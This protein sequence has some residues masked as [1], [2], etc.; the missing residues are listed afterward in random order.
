M[1]TTFF[2]TITTVSTIFFITLVLGNNSYAEI[3]TENVL[4]RARNFTDTL[5]SATPPTDPVSGSFSFDYDD[6]LPDG[7]HFLKPSSVS[8]IIDGVDYGIPANA[9]NTNIRVELYSGD[10]IFVTFYF[11][12]LTLHMGANDFK[13]D[14]D[15]PTA[16]GLNGMSYTSA[17]FSI[18]IFDTGDAQVLISDTCLGDSDGDKDV[19]GVDLAEYI[20]DSGGLGLDEFVMDFGKINCP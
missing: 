1:R 11:S 3:V 8:L 13:L 14:L 16:S 15:F 19:D 5:S 2:L 17:N 9:S 18:S 7:I 4:F 10:L 20:F 12:D 6:T